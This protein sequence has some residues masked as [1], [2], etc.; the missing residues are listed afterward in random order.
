MKK[1]ILFLTLVT[2][3]GVFSAQDLRAQGKPVSKEEALKFSHYIETETNAGRPDALNGVFD[4]DKLIENIGKYSK[5][6]ADKSF[7][8]GFRSGFAGSMGTYGVKITTS[9]RGGSYQLLKAYEKDGS[10]HLLFRMYGNGGLNY[11]DYILTRTKDSVKASDCYVYTTDEDLSKTM[12]KLLDMMMASS[13]STTEIPEEVKMVTTLND[14]KNKGDYAGAKQY[15]DKLTDRTKDNKAVQ[16]IY[17]SVCQHLDKN[18]YQDQLEHYAMLYPSSSSGYL[19]MLDLYFLKKEYNKGLTA[20]NKLDTLVGKDPFLDFYR[21][22][23]YQMGG[24]KEQALAC[25]ERV[26]RY[27]PQIT[28]NTNE[29]IVA[30]LDGNQNDKAKKV[31]AEYKKSPAFRQENLNTLYDKYPALK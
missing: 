9:T 2:F 8:D 12:G 20:V 1:P 17:L 15:Y 27:D 30:Y 29:L 4:L 5:L 26:Y 7:I 13:Q 23:F 11:H 18:L 14:L 3:L 31:V 6:M 21:G 28:S 19:L 16:V 24:M 10:Q 25:Y 22:I